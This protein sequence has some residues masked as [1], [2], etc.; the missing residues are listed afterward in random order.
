MKIKQK[1]KARIKTD[2]RL[3]KIDAEISKVYSTQ[4]ALLSVEKKYAEYMNTVKAQTAEE[5]EAYQEDPEKKQ[6][7]INKVRSLTLQSTE[8]KRLVNKIVDVL[9]QVNQQALDVVNNSMA[10]IYAINYDQVAEECRHVGIKIN[11]KK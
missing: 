10:D 8:Y 4:P 1:D 2:Q 3:S 5:Y 7:Y 9:A 11:G 6:A